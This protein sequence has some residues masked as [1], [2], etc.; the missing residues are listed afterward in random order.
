MSKRQA[1]RDCF[2]STNQLKVL[3][4]LAKFSD[5]EFHEREIARRTAAS[6]GSANKVLNQLFADGTLVRRQAGKMLFYSFNSADPI[7]KTFKI[8]VSVSL[9]R[10]LV[11]NLREFA[12]E[13]V[14]YGS[15]ARGED[16]SASDMDLF[17]V[18]AEREKVLGIMENYKFRK[19]F[20]GIKIEP[21]ILSALELLKSEK[22]DQE[23]LSLVR[24]GIV[25]WDEMKDEAG[26]Q[27][28]PKPGQDRPV[29]PGKKT[30]Q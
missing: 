2:F 14:L 15:C 12:A 26:V 3:S 8:F 21:V 7:A 10:P 30:G 17:V 20:E 19:G 4:F 5:Q 16:T 25:L 24:E 6:Y 27:G 1:I 18:S 9:L 23:F 11:K 28:V 22:T 13:I 29:S